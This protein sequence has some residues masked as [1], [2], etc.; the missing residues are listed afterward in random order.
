M[1]K[2]TLLLVGSCIG[3][4]CSCYSYK[5][6]ST[7][8]EIEKYVGKKSVYVLKAQTDTGS[9]FF[10]RS[11]P[12]LLTDDHISGIYQYPLAHL[13]PDSVFYRKNNLKHIDYAYKDGIRYDV[14]IEN[15]QVYIYDKLKKINIL[16][17]DVKS[18][19]LKIFQPG[20]TGVL[21]GGIS[22]GFG[23]IIAIV[24]L[25]TTFETGWGVF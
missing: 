11:L 13:K 17:K 5:E 14:F 8:P 20:S 23:I 1:K 2:S 12:G 18:I 10:S 21:V 3:F 4:L 16:F 15:K 19:Y 24:F 7:L 9:V 22:A 25:I 6:I